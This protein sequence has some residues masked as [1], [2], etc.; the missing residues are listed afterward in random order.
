MA[1]KENQNLDDALDQV[2]QAANVAPGT[3][4]AGVADVAK[5]VDPCDLWRRIR[6]QVDSAIQIL[7]QIGRFLPV[8]RRIADVL[9]LLK[10]ILDQLCRG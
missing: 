10:G 5:R 4:A 7:D 8:A 2:L 9:R 3:E 1:N 6:G